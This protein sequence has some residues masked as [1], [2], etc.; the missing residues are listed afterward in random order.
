MIVRPN[1]PGIV[2]HVTI[3]LPLLL[4]AAGAVFVSDV[5]DWGRLVGFLLCLVLPIAIG[6]ALLVWVVY[7]KRIHSTRI[8]IRRK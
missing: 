3:L 2:V 8:W 1:L 4:G 7:R 6:L 5:L